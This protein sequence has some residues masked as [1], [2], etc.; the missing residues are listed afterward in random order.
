MSG[1]A[2][3]IDGDAPSLQGFTDGGCLVMP[4]PLYHNGPAMWVCG[5]LLAGSH[6][7]ILPRFDAEGTLRAIE[8]HGAT[9]LYMVP[10]MM[11]RMSALP[12]D[13]RQ[14]LEDPP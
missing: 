6:S 3:E 12:D 11:K 13:V 7:V 4:G 1:D 8:Q 14:R 2:A 9:V 5:A 10:T